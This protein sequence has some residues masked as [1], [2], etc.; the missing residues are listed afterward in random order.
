VV[1]GTR[2]SHRDATSNGFATPVWAAVTSTSIEH[3]PRGRRQ[4][5]T[6][7]Y[8]SSAEAAIGAA[9]RVITTVAANFHRVPD[10]V[11]SVMDY[12]RDCGRDVNV[13]VV[14][15][16]LET[17]FSASLRT[18]EGEPTRCQVAFVDPSDPDPGRPR[19][20]VQDRWRITP[21]GEPIPFTVGNVVKLASATDPRT[22]S[23]VVFG[24]SESDVVIW[25]LVDQ[26][27]RYHDFVNLDSESG[28]PPP[29]IFLASIDGAA[30]VSVRRYFAEIATL[31]VDRL[32]VDV[33]D[34]LWQ[35][36]LA[37]ALRSGIASY[38]DA[39]EEAVG[40]EAFGQRD[41]WAAALPG[42]W[43]SALSRVLLRARRYGH[44]GALLITP[45]GSLAGLNVKY[46]LPY[47]RLPSALRTRAVATISYV[48]ASDE[49]HLLLDDDVD[50]LPVGLYLDEA[51]SDSD[52]EENRSEIDGVLWFISL[53]TRVDGLVAL[54]PDLSVV[55]FGVE[56]VVADE[57]ARIVRAQDAARDQVVEI[58]YTQWGTR[59]R[60][61]MRYCWSVPGSVGFVLSQDGDI[62]AMTRC[63]DEL[64]VWENPMLQMRIEDR[65]L[66]LNDAGE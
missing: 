42:Y 13:A 16:V 3:W 17:L 49:I 6:Y 58:S 50:D 29:G 54:G 47:D 8:E 45:D 20:I 51:V 41:E 26:G 33:V 28:P 46:A 48:N 32:V 34:A 27:N 63:G 7:V 24:E 39:V 62:R 25:G 44:G 37:A 35:G 65:D 22:S 40:S 55:G 2:H 14:G 43:L 36:P 61:M 57:P 23:L 19:R 59:H 52:R 15:Q 31:R 38:I 1:I 64:V 11:A 60:S 56:V 10:L 21:L 18:E 53:L 5:V 4:V 66:V 12:L 9:V 30:I